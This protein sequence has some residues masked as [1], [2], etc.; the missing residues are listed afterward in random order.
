[1]MN[2]AIDHATRRAWDALHFL[3]GDGT[4]HLIDVE[5][6]VVRA[7]FQC[8]SDDERALVEAQLAQSYFVERMSGG[9]INVLRFYAPDQALTIPGPKFAE[10]LVVVSLEVDGKKQKAH[11]TF[12]RGYVFSVE[13]AEEG[14]KYSRRHVRVLGVRLG[15]PEQSFTVA[16]DRQE[17]DIDER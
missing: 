16:I 3:C 5:C 17:H 6:Q 15:R 13:F 11:M 1:M 4:W 12:Y 10:L 9:R 8:L 7:A 14:R 2:A